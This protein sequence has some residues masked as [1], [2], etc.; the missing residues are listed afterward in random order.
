[1]SR[2]NYSS[3]PFIWGGTTSSLIPRAIATM[4]MTTKINPIRS[5]GISGIFPPIRS[6]RRW[7]SNGWLWAAAACF[8]M[9]PPG[10]ISASSALPEIWP[11]RAA[12]QSLISHYNRRNSS[13]WREYK[14]A[15]VRKMIFANIRK[16]LSGEN[17]VNARLYRF[18]NATVR[19]SAPAKKKRLKI[20]RKTSLLGH[21]E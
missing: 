9:P 11:I 6:G 2:E 5:P 3:L 16:S 17:R 12:W 4:K 14:C 15:S 13:E 1:M 7:G 18:R 20:S 21:V 19:K 8:P 10:P